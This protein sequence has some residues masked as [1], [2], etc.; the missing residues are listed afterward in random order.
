MYPEYQIFAVHARWSEDVPEDAEQ[1]TGRWCEG[2][3]PSRRW[4]SCFFD[5]MPQENKTLEQIEI[6]AREV[7]WPSFENHGENVADLS[8]NVYFQRWAAWCCG[9]FGHWTYDT[10]IDEGDITDS[11]HSYV[12]FQMDENYRNGRERGY[13]LM[14]AD[15]FRRWSAPC[16]CEH[17]M[18]AGIVR[19]DH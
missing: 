14:G 3:P 1:P 12:A 18:A 8:I 5:K 7:W 10:F 11:F 15:E 17:C 13:D 19:I 2:L 6:E 4:N 16:R 9:W